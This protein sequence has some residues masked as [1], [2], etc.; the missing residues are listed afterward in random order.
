M[1]LAVALL[2]VS[3]SKDKD[4]APLERGK[5]IS[6]S[7]VGSKTRDQVVQSVDELNASD[8]AIHNV[9]FYKIT[10]RSEYRGKGIETDGLLVVPNGVAA[11]HLIG[12]FHGTKL[13][14][15]LLN[16][17][18][19]I[20]SLYKG[21]TTDFQ[22][23]RNMGLTWASAGYAVFLPDY[24]GFGSTKDRE[25]PY[26]HYPELFKANVD[27]LLA[28]QRF[29]Q[30]RGL[31]TGNDVLL[32]GWSQGGGAALSAHRYIQS[33]YADRI[34]VRATSALAGPHNIRRFVNSFLVGDHA[35][36]AMPIYSWG[37]YS[38]NK[39]SSLRRPTDQIWMYP[40]YDQMSSVFC[41]SNVPSQVFIPHFANAL[42]SGTDATGVA[43]LNSLSNHTGWTPVGKV[44]LHHGDADSVVLPF[45]SVDAYEGLTAAGGDVTLY[46]YP[47]G[48]HD[49]ELGNFIRRTLTDFN[50]L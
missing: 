40:V 45:N 41:P 33:D 30:D 38:V 7:E 16:V 47:G 32:T 22:E 34:T 12:Y 49:T 18:K 26:I 3:C 2:L 19:E 20:P 36:D 35:M 44:F 21:E 4:D 43:V 5:L 50:A 13:Q 14:L 29:L 28:A 42:V 48:K 17:D 9:T 24:I 15:D 23:V 6:A 11:P 46:L 27:G 25:H 10:Y 37:Y 8:L 1:T 31:S 39:F